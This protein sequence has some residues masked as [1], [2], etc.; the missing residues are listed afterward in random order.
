MHTRTFVLC[1]L[2]ALLTVGARAQTTINASQKIV[3]MDTTGVEQ[4]LI[5]IA[6]TRPSYDATYRAIRSANHSLSLA[7]NEWLNLL[8]ISL[9]FNDQEFYHQKSVPG[10]TTYVYPKYFFGVTIPIGVIFSR[11]SE[12]RIARE[13]QAIAKDNQA[14][15]A[16]TIIANVKAKY[17]TYLDYQ[18]VLAV[19]N[20][21]VND[22]QA[23]FLQVEKNFRDGKIT[24]DDYTNASRTFNGSIL[25]QLQY[26]IS[27]DQIKVDL[28]QMLGMTLEEALKQ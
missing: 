6:L 27:C 28:E 1:L 19:E 4:K 25:A 23:A 2:L 15:A 17:R 7:K 9:N 3:G 24:L 10:Q 20:I 22:Q 11:S 16:R 26:K 8:S 12:I 18:S 21:M 13:N 5:R 14:E